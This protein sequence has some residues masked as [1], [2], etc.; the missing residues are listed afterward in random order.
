MIIRDLWIIN[1]H[2]A[3]RP[4]ALPESGSQKT[5]KRMWPMSISQIVSRHTAWDINLPNVK[6][7]WKSDK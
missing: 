5:W 7:A 3:W 4:I 6:V 1:I 2:M